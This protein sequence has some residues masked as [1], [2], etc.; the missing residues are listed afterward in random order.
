M[1]LFIACDL[2]IICSTGLA[3]T[4]AATAPDAAEQTS[5]FGIALAPES[6]GINDSCR[7]RETVSSIM[8]VGARETQREAAPT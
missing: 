7:T 6:M 5:S 2:V 4:Q 3:T 1:P 8:T